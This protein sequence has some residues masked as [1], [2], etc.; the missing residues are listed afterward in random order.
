MQIPPQYASLGRLLNKPIDDPAVVA[1]GFQPPFP[2]F[3]QLL[4]ARATLGQSLRRWPQYTGVGTGGMN[5]HSGNSTYDALIV[6][7]TKRFSGGLSMLADYTW[8]KLLTDADSSEPWIAGVVGSGVGAGAAQNNWNRRVEKS[9]GVLDMAHMFKLTASYD[10]PFGPRRRY[11]SSGVFGHVLGDWNVAAFIYGQSGYPLGVVDDGYSNFLMG[12]RARPNVTSLDWRA[13]IV[14]DRFDPSNGPYL[15]RTAFQ[16]RTD[17][18]VDPFGNAPRLNGATRS[19]GR[20][21]E[22][23]SLARTIPIKER[24]HL[25]FRWEIYN[26]FNLKTWN[27]PASMDLSNP[28]FGVV[29]NASGNRTMQAGLK[30]IF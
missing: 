5:N 16:R 11:F 9:Y 2:N 6:K 27:N 8:S 20:F 23:I 21:R 24:A 7:L 13:P 26:L 1:L 18:R 14:G 30:L 17:P 28:L 3:K 10:L 25:D 15:N 29:T 12:G 19:P 4:G 22:N